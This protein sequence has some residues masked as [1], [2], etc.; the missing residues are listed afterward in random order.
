MSW[1]SAVTGGEKVL[2]QKGGKP[3]RAGDRA[4]SRITGRGLTRVAALDLGTNNCR[5]LIAD[6]R[7]RSYKVIDS[8]SRIVRLG[9]GLSENGAL[10]DIAIGRA[11]DALTICAERLKKRGV[12]NYRA[13]ATQACRE[14]SNGDG[15]L[16]HIREKV[17]IDLEIIS[18]AE[19]ASL[20]VNGCAN[21]LLP[22]APV[23]IVFD[24]GGGST[25]VSWVKPQ[26]KNGRFEILASHSFPF[27]VVSLAERWQGSESNI[28]QYEAL[29][30]DVGSEISAIGDPAGV[31]GLLEN[32]AVHL[33]GTSGTMTSLAGVHLGL[34]RYNRSEVDGLWMTAEEV[35][36]VARKLR[37]MSFEERAALAC[38]GEAR[39]DLVISGA[40][41]FEAL[42]REWPTRRVRVADRGLREGLL[43]ELVKNVRKKQRG[44]RRAPRRYPYR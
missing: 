3:G 38:I 44:S 15:F 39:A 32:E 11:T 2:H 43:A 35:R 5:L 26:A 21:L 42:M 14:A 40:A 28:T 12:T 25:E 9:E 1:C 17:G 4:D 34:R 18:P 19:E 8:F 23:G 31:R 20:S 24:I 16:S 36:T 33:L 13:V 27:G 10:S 29:V 7:G 37:S 41:I 30:E 22:H 6:L